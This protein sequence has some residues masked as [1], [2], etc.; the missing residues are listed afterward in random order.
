MTKVNLPFRL[1]DAL[2]NVLPHIHV[3]D[4]GAMVLGV[5][6]PPYAQFCRPGHATVTG[7]EPHKEECE[8][9]N[10]LKDPGIRFLPYCL[11]DGSK[12]TFY[13]TK[14]K[15]TSSLYPPNV[16]LLNAF[17]RLEEISELDHPEKVQTVRLDD[18]PEVTEAHYLKIDVQGAALDVLRGAEKLLATTLVVYTEVEF[19]EMYAGQPLFAEVDT[20]LRSHGFMF[21]CFDDI[22]GRPFAPVQI[23]SSAAQPVR[24]Q[25]WADAIYVRDFRR[26]H[27]LTPQQLIA[28][29]VM[30]HDAFGSVDLASVALN[31]FDRKMG[32]QLWK[33]LMTKFT[34]SPSVT[35]APPLAGLD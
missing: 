19:V 14:A 10:A 29:A 4:A 3:I 8:K 26:F 34:G 31:H 21:H 35:P 24:Q 30:V 2:R 15:Y 18:I 25:L 27:E 5:E 12:R 17:A 20:F 13:V 28:L 1:A 33:T 23:G 6:A 32:T 9:V 22:A 11:G 7:F 16:P